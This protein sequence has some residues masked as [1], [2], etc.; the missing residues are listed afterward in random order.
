MRSRSIE[1]HGTRLHGLWR[2]G[3][4]DPLIVVPGVLADAEAFRPV[5]EAIDRPEPV[6]IVDRRGREPSGP[7]GPDYSVAVEVADLRAWI[8]AIGPRVRLI[9]WS[10]GGT[11]A[12]ET[13]ALDERVL[14]TIAYEPGLGPFGAAAL[15]RLRQADADR[16]VEIFNLEISQFPVE[17][18]EA[19]RQTPAWPEL[20]RLSGPAAEE[21][22]AVNAFSPDG[23]WADVS[24][25]LILGE[26]NQH[27]GPYFE[28]FHR[29]QDRLP[30]ARTTIL[31]G[32]GHL[33]HAEDP[34]ALGRLITELLGRS[35]RGGSAE[36]E[37][38]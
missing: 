22:G 18:V 1:R 13:A 17:H 38:L 7:L 15:P 6:L 4:G 31:A 25:E 37:G 28:I 29:A 33:A 12:I 19:L 30:R 5:V 20:M 35:G 10:Y 21:L 14:G 2:D 32:H 34:T 27:A 24:A 16:R 3:D 26:H 8:S 23:G 9:G 36:G 11:I